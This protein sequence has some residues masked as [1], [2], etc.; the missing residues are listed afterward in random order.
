MEPLN[1]TIDLQS[2]GGKVSGAKVWV[3]SQFQT[4]DQGA[5]AKT[6]GVAPEKVELN[7]MMAGGGFGRRAVP[8]SDYVV[9]AASVAK[10]YA[11]AGHS[12]PVKVIWSREDD[13][14]GGYYRPMHLHRVD[15]G[16]DGSGKVLGWNHVI[17]GQSITKNT[18]FEPYTFKNGVDATMAE[19]VIENDYG[20]P[21]QVS[22]H[23]PNVDVP[24]LWWRSVGHTHTAFVM[25]TLVDEV[26]HAARQ[27]PVAYRLARFTGKAQRTPSR[28]TAARRQQVRLRQAQAAEGAGVGCGGA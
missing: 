12:G 28:G 7:T 26:A 23:H 6:L 22:V 11:A 19:G 3:G 17:V 14:R 16:L 27:D 4:V 8:T 5:L 25:E 15:I 10:A 2:E 1:C 24:V 13:I 21:M 18:L 9:E 20:F